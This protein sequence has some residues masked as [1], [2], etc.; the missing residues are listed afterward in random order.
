MAIPGEAPDLIEVR[1]KV[2]IGEKAKTAKGKEYPKAVDHFI[3]DDPEVKALGQTSELLITFPYS[4]ADENFSTGL[5]WW[6]GKLLACYTKDGGDNPV[7]LRVHGMQMGAG[8]DRKEVSYLDPDDEIVNEAKVGQGRVR[9]KCRAN[10]CRHFEQNADKKECRPMGRL[11]FFLKDGRVDKCLQLETK[12]WGTIRGVRKVL[13]GAERSGPLAGR[14]FRLTVKMERKGDSRF[15]IVSIEEVENVVINNDRDVEL[16]D[17]LVELRLAV[18]S[19]VGVREALAG[20]L[21]VTTPGWRE[22]A[23]VIERIREVGVEQAAAK[24]LERYEA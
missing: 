6:K 18:D 4:S 17:K 16:A 20:V 13:K 19:T 1:G 9:I 15:P 10:D 23:D 22:R 2:R 5:E 8:N 12:A 21:D 3:S 24:T 11:V 7:A 14:V